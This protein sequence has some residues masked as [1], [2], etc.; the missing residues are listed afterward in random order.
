MQAPQQ[1]QAVKATPEHEKFYEVVVMAIQ[2]QCRKYPHMSGKEVVAI[3]AR[4]LG[5]AIAMNP[6]AADRNI[7][8]QIAIRNIA[9][10]A[11]LISAEETDE[12]SND[13]AKPG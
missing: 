6:D 13:Q 3:V 5:Y 9:A 2:G 4:S 1:P 11:N 10:A 7:Q 12:E 8:F